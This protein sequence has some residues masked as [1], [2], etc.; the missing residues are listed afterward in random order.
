MLAVSTKG[1]ADTYS[2]SVKDDL[3]IAY[4][5]YYVIKECNEA[6]DFI[7][8]TYD[9]DVEWA[10]EWVIAIETTL[11]AKDT[12]LD[13]DALWKESVADEDVQSFVSMLGLIGLNLGGT[14]PDLNCADEYG[15]HMIGIGRAHG[16]LAETNEKDF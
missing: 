1:F 2:G 8:A 5:S 3:K 4:V 14:V 10:K 12:T 11:L 9:H 6:S 16:L 15:K 13:P 7:T